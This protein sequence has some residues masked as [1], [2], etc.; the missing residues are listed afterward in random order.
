MRH[1]FIFAVMATL[2]SI[3]LPCWAAPPTAAS[4]IAA[5]DQRFHDQLTGNVAGLA[6]D[7]SDE[8]I[9][10]HANGME[11]NKAQFLH[12]GGSGS[13]HYLSITASRRTAT[14]YGNFGITHELFSI[15]IGLGHLLTSVSSGVYIMRDGRWQLLLWQS[16]EPQQPK[17]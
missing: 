14:I 13:P 5:E 3:V 1:N 4:L 2:P 7:M 6:K 10:T 12:A 17:K 16:T 8:L 11:Q 9:F 15:D